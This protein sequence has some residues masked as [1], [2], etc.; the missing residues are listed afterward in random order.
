MI[1]ACTSVLCR[2]DTK[3]EP[4]YYV[5]VI[6]DMHLTIILVWYMHVLEYYDGVIHDMYLSIM[7]V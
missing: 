3:H 7:M 4:E 5:G 6:C 2:C 1:H